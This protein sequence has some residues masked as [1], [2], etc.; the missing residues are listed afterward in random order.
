MAGIKIT[1]LPALSVA[2]SADYLCIV[3]VSDTSASPAGTTKKI[4][5]SN[6]A[7]SGI[8]YPIDDA[9]LSAN[10][11]SGGGSYGQY[12]VS[13]KLMT[14]GVYFQSLDIDF[15]ADSGA[16]ID[17]TLPAGYVAVSA[18]GSASIMFSTTPIG[19]ATPVF[20]NCVYGNS[21]TVK[22]YLQNYGG[23]VSNIYDITAT[24]VIELA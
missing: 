21:G 4:E 18:S 10:V 5:L 17:I 20:S 9:V 7:T 1:D 15:D 3:D 24:F 8:F 16:T 13:G 11:T 12:F 22:I 6:V 19:T 23:E 14:L 2:D